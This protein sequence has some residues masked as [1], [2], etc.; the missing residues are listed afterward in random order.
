[1]L[2]VGVGSLEPSPLLRA[3]GNAIAEE[4]QAQLRG[5]GAVGDI[6]LRFFDSGGAHVDSPLDSRVVGIAADTLRSVPRRVAVAGGDR[7]FTAI[8]AA[9]RGGWLS[10][11]VT[12]LGVARRLAAEG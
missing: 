11:L 10:A 9:L 2:L 5:L 1:M 12:D 4:D 3:S 7:K 6:C 8:R